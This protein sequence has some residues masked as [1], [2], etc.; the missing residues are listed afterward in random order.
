MIGVQISSKI[1]MLHKIHVRDP[2]PI[3]VMEGVQIVSSTGVGSHWNCFVNV[4]GVGGGWVGGVEDAVLKP[5]I[6]PYKVH[7][8]LH[9]VFLKLMNPFS[10]SRVIDA[11]KKF[12][13]YQ[14]GLIGGSK[15]E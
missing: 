14:R 15:C 6:H 3:K 4:G 11:F 9:F 8:E 12:L 2:H 5:P 13:T 1:P 10:H 7:E